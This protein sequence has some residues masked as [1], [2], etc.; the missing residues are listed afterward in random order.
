MSRTLGA[1]LATDIPI[2][3]SLEL[4][5]ATV[6]NVH[7]RRAIAHLSRLP[8]VSES[9]ANALARPADSPQ[10]ARLQRRT[11]RSL[12]WQTWRAARRIRR[13]LY[14]EHEALEELERAVDSAEQQPKV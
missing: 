7:Y 10:S 2:V 14:E 1:L 4:T 6:Q 13:V 12:R 5:A 3:R 9:A 8:A 11:V